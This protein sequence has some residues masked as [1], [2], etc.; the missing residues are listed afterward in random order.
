MQKLEFLLVLSKYEIQ[1]N[2]SPKNKIEDS[3]EF[4][5]TTWN[6]KSNHIPFKLTAQARINVQ[7][8][9]HSL[10][11][12]VGRSEDPGGGGYPVDIFM[13]SSSFASLD[14]YST[15]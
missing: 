5:Y 3:F 1:P 12:T 10:T 6:I 8:Q 4:L 9:I 11:R 13:V 15:R 14:Q 2:M 7:S